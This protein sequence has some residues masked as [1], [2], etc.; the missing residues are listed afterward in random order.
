MLIPKR[1]KVG[2]IKP[3]RLQDKR[4]LHFVAGLACC[5]CKRK[6]VQCHH[7]LRGPVR[8]I[9]LRAGDDQVIPLCPE[10]HQ[11]LHHS[12]DEIGFLTGHGINGMALAAK[13]WKESHEK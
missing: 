9:G 12:G 8:G 7:L 13:L 2:R 1:Q 5:C 10:C 11:K 4:H 6:P 3:K